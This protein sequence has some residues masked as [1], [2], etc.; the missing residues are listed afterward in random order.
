MMSFWRR[1]GA[2]IAAICSAGM[3]SITASG[4]NPF[5]LRYEVIPV[6]EINRDELSP[7]G[8]RVLRQSDRWIAGRSE[9]FYAL[10][11]SIRSVSSA[12]DE[13]EFAWTWLHAWLGFTNAPDGRSLVVIVDD[14]GM[15]KSLIKKHGLRHDSL[16]MQIQ[17]ELYLKD[18]PEQAVRPDRIAHEI[19]HVRLSRPDKRSIP[20]WLEEGL[21][22]YAGWRCAIEYNR[23]KGITLYRNQPALD[24]TRILSLADLLAQDEYP[25][26][27][28]AAIAFYHQSE[29]L[30]AALIENFGQDA[31]VS[32]I[33]KASMIKI[34][35]PEELR[36]ALRTE[37]EQIDRLEQQV[38]QRCREAV[39][40]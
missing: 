26:E 29:E 38:K 19:V 24:D 35:Q 20:L 13:A 5:R 32:L 6:D 33:E 2:P 9:N 7:L 28:E 31:V 15:W 39:K 21:A 17:R 40:Y 30:V 25:S 11:S 8:R 34:D 14:P 22:N 27:P 4:E 36:E 18:D 37:Q 10:G 1:Y 23:T 16:A 12:V 3:V